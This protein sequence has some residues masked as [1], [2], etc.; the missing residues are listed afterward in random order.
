M[1]YWCIEIRWKLLKIYIE[2][3]VN[4]LV[5]SKSHTANWGFYSITLQC[6]NQAGIVNTKL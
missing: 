5:V 4:G 2:I 6:L 1:N 3:I